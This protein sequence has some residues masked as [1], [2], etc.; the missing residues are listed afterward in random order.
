MVAP[1]RQGA[2]FCPALVRPRR[3]VSQIVVLGSRRA[4]TAIRLGVASKTIAS[5]RF[6]PVIGPTQR[7]QSK[8]IGPAGRLIR[9]GENAARR[10]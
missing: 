9:Q 4:H 1:D 2:K 10:V 8:N 3:R 6:K 5:D 7:R